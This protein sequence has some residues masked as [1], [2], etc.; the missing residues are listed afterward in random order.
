MLEKDSFENDKISEASPM[1]IAY[2]YHIPFA[3]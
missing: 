1:K 3:K 2:K